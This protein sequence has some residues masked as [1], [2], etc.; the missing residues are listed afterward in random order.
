MARKSREKREKIS[1]ST[2]LIIMVVFVLIVSF[3]TQGFFI[4][5]GMSRQIKESQSENFTII[6]QSLT[7]F[8]DLEIQSTERLVKSYS[9]QISEY[10]DATGTDQLKF[11][12]EVHDILMDL[13]YE[14]SYFESAFLMNGNGK[15]LDSTYSTS[16]IGADLSDREYFRAI[17]DERKDTYTTSKA[18]ISEATG[19]LT[20][21]CSAAIRANGE[22]KGLLAI[23]LNLTSFANSFVLNKKIGRTGY[24][25]VLDNEGLIL[26]HP[27][28][29]LVFTR[30]QDVDPFFQ[31]VIDSK[32]RVQVISYELGGVRKEGVFVRMPGTGWIICLA[33]NYSEAFRSILTLRIMLI[34][35]SILLIVI[36]S[37]ILAFYI[38]KRLVIK[39]SQ[40]EKILFQASE[41]NLTVQGTV[42]GRD[43]VAGMT[44]Y[45]NTFLESLKGFFI[46]LKGNLDELDQVGQELSANMEETAAALYQIRTN[47]TNSRDH[48]DQQESSVNE[49]AAVVQ[50]IIRNIQKLDASISMQDGNIQQGSSAIEE[51]IAQI[52]N[53]SSSTEEAE[54][55]METLKHSSHQGRE[56]LNTVSGMIG[57]IAEKSRNLEEA[58]TLIAGI[59]AKTNLLAMNA[60]IEAAHA[61]AAGRGFAVVAD[62]IRNLAEQSTK[63]SSEVKKTILDISQSISGIV[64]ASDTTSSSFQEIE[65]NMDAMARITGEIKFS[66]EEQVAGSTQVLQ[67]LQEMKT[68]G[69]DVLSGSREMTEG[70]QKILKTV[71]SLTQ[72]SSE[73]SLAMKEIGHGMDE[74]KSSIQN[75]S[76]IVSR[77]KESI[78]NV[79]TGAS[80]Y[81][82]VEIEESE[83]AE[84][85][86]SDPEGPLPEEEGEAS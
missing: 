29:E 43:E 24:P 58:N 63:Q 52:K 83:T 5:T 74:I 65:G 33:I 61:G 81:Q 21:V 6:T 84:L 68:A 10:L 48:I 13:A 39:L 67:S 22:L 79:K 72:I 71:E 86:Y 46:S 73:V 38:R 3:L 20:V 37:L 26:I 23:S 25:Y 18:L 2:P 60:A 82:T 9:D 64:K 76:D 8:M 32:E 28:K 4:L 16:M 51:M 70:N 14:S 53:V 11:D 36:I 1:F 17:M 31:T 54:N 47:V 19:N 66:M 55:I 40:I 15:V 41:G 62:E 44:G 59:A 30:S 85:D 75:V 35:S 42:K 57:T 27:S 77:N 50:E 45:I 7:D 56:N 49:T 12:L 69:M 34:A 78:S 80:I